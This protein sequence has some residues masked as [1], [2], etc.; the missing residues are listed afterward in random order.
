MLTKRIIPLFLLK[1]G[2]IYKGER[3]KNFIDVGDPTSQGMIYD[4]Q[5]ADEIIIVDIEA[6]K[7]KKII[8]PRMISSMITKCRLPIAAGGGIRDVK[9]A[10]EC[11][12]AGADKIIVNTHAV[13]NPRL[14]KEMARE[15]GSQ[16]VV[17][18]IDVKKSGL[19]YYDVYIY[20]GTRKIRVKLK[21]LIKKLIDCGAGEIIVTCID[22][23]GTMSG[24]DCNL[25]SGLRKLVSVP[26]IASGGA[27]SYDHMVDLFKESDCDAC[28]IG[29]MIF[30][31]DYD[32]VRIKAY[33]KGKDVTVREA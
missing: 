15:F 31:R 19:N 23:E 32:I 17:V 13:L 3:F 14:V 26:L 2:R 5:G 7:K 9:S 21:D 30:L 25:Y 8:D 22:K 12:S 16:S 29:K 10:K 33:L 27:G 6:S 18:S 4:A 28:A 11:F 24:F 1:E 20:S